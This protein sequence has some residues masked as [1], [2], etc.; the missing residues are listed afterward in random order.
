[1]LYQES[2]APLRAVQSEIHYHDRGHECAL[3]ALGGLLRPSAF[4]FTVFFACNAPGYAGASGT[5]T[6]RQQVCK[7]Q[8][9]LCKVSTFL[10]VGWLR[11]ALFLLAPPIGGAPIEGGVTEA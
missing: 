5:V 6:V 1:M 3:L 9:V 8:F 10:L 11:T 2:E 4:G 7:Y